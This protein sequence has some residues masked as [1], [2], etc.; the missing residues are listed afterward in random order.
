MN[1]L[2]STRKS[3]VGVVEMRI[4]KIHLTIKQST[5][6]WTTIGGED[7]TKEDMNLHRM[8]HSLELVGAVRRELGER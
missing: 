2:Q 7:G 8:A 4:N 1:P 3:L 6:R 5:G